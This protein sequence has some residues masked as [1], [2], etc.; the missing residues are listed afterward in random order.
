MTTL[1]VV[2]V[3]KIA[4]LR[5]S[6]LAVFAGHI[7]TSLT[8]NTNFTG[9]YP[10]LTV[11]SAA[12]T[13]L[14]TA[15]TNQIK[16]VK[17]TTTAVRDAETQVRRVLKVMAAV[18]EYISNNNQTI[19]LSSGFSI[20]SHTPKTVNDFNAL[21]GLLTGS[22]NVKSKAFIDGSYIFQYTTTP[23]VPASWVTSATLKQVKHTITGLTPGVMYYFRVIVITRTGQQA[24]STPINLM[25]V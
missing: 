11:L 1:K 6:R 8:G 9:I 15:V 5:G 16:G 25:V 2:V 17:S 4:G 21:H 23:L 10:G 3:L 18:V 20:K 19:A 14:N 7:L 24:P 12:I 22:V 13:A